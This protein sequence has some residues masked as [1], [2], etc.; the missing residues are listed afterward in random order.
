MPLH[1]RLIRAVTTWPSH[2][3]WIECLLAGAAATALITILA[4]I[5]GLLRYNPDLSRLS[6]MVFLIP[7][8]TEELIFRGP[9]PTQDDMTRPILWLGLG[10]VIFTLWHVVEAT[11]FL[12]GA[13]LFLTP[14]FLACAAVLGAACAWMRYR[15]GSLWPGVLF[16]GIV[17]LVWQVLFSGL[18]V[19]D[20]R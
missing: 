9:L 5:T 10:V 7:A 1:H 2:K 19:V 16:H 20:L 3:G 13:R 18:S 8:F 17:V 15:T 14:G 6:P 12:P 11:T 4:A